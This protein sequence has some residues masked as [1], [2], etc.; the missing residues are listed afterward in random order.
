MKRA[1]KKG[2]PSDSLTDFIRSY[3]NEYFMGCDMVGVQ[4]KIYRN[5]NA[6]YMGYV[7]IDSTKGLIY[8]SKNTVSHLK[9]WIPLSDD[10]I[11]EIIRD[12][13][14]NCFNIDLRHVCLHD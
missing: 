9:S 7:E 13:A 1:L 5:L 3:I 6:F 10:V 11:M 2:K 8:I 12:E 14:E 4:L